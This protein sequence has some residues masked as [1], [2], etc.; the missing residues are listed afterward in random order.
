M[1]SDAHVEQLVEA[2]AEQVFGAVHATE[3]LEGR[4]RHA[5][6]VNPLCF[7]AGQANARIL[8]LYLV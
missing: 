4:D 3:V 8:S 1:L 2:V 6:A 7:L 5:R